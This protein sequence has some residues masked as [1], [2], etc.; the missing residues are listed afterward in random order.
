MNDKVMNLLG[1]FVYLP[2]T[3]LAVTVEPFPPGEYTDTEVLTNIPIRV[4]LE[5]LDR[6]RFVR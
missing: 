5:R 1:S 4:D 2:A 6:I 3:A